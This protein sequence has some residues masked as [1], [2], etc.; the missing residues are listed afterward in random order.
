MGCD[1]RDTKGGCES[2]T[3]PTEPVHSHGQRRS[4]VEYSK[5]TRHF[6]SGVIS[7]AAPFR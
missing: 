4:D 5:H 2:M 6:T 1:A 7:G 3:H